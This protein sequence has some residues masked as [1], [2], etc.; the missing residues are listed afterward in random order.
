MKVSHL[1]YLG[2]NLYGEYDRFVILL[3]GYIDYGFIKVSMTRR[4]LFSL[5]FPN[6]LQA[7]HIILVR[8]KGVEGD[9][10]ALLLNIN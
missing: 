10:H 3:N 4:E 5:N 1:S 8:K 2:C 6:S 9:F 7:D